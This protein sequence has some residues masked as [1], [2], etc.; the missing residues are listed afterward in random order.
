M[1]KQEASLGEVVERKSLWSMFTGDS[2]TPH[3]EGCGLNPET[4]GYSVD[5]RLPPDAEFPFSM[6]MFYS[7]SVPSDKTTVHCGNE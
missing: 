5:H 7:C 3:R 4:C 1:S 2:G 6:H